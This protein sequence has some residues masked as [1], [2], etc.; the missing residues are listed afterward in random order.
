MS[1][2]RRLLSF[3]VLGA[4]L[5]ISPLDK[6]HAEEVDI[7]L[8]LA[9]LRDSAIHARKIES[10]GSDRI[11]LSQ[12]LMMLT[13]RV[14]WSS[15]ALTSEVAVDESYGQLEDAMN[16]VNVIFDALTHGNATL[17]IISTEENPQTLHR[18][19]ALREAWRETQAAI[20]AALTDGHGVL[21]AHVIDDQNLRLLEKTTDFSSEILGQYSHPFE[22]TQADALTVQIAGRQ[23][24][25]IQKMSKDACEIWSGQNLESG[26]KE[27]EETMD[28]FETSLKAL[29]Y[30]YPEVG[31]LPAPTPAIEADVEAALARW[32]TMR[33]TLE[34][35]L[36]GEVPTAEMK[37]EIFD[38]FNAQ[39][40]EI[41]HL[42]H[43]YK[44]YMKRHHG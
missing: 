40:R 4:A 42:V 39:L 8:F 29:R 36:A 10:D 16:E 43:D 37:R 28:V 27:L 3:L 17:N 25:L 14:A 5:V 6:S 24:M 22:M 11:L 34:M 26:R 21:S 15:C 18:I 2:V 31:V 9:K 44:A 33:E 32:E 13:Q 41:D 35:L 7:A 20:S 30:G 19:E 38:S 1:D 23:R 12:R